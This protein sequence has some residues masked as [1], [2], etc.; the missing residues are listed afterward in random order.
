M[1]IFRWNS[2]PSPSSLHTTSGEI[3]VL[4]KRATKGLDSCIRVIFHY[5][6]PSA[7]SSL[8]PVDR[9]RLLAVSLSYRKSVGFIRYQTLRYISL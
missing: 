6:I 3:L 7:V 4:M 2:L 9:S 1:S 8:F 5:L